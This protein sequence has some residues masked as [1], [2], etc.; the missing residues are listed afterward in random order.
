[1]GEVQWMQWFIDWGGSGKS[2][3]SFYCQFHPLP[4]SVHHEKGKGHV[5]LFVFTIGSLRTHILDLRGRCTEYPNMHVF[6]Q[7]SQSFS[8]TCTTLV[9]SLACPLSLTWSVHPFWQISTQASLAHFYCVFCQP[10]FMT[11]LEMSH[12]AQNCFTTVPWLDP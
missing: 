5:A 8:S 2:I 7:P 12:V 1:M 6:S 9:F 4:T 11:D 3:S 10:C